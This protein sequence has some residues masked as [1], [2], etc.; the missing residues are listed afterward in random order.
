MY[1]TDLG[2]KEKAAQLEAESLEQEPMEEL[3]LEGIVSGLIDS[4][5]DYIDMEI[6]PERTAAEDYYNGKEFG[7]EEAGRSRVVSM[8]V[9]D[10]ISLMMPQIMR[11]FFGPEKVVEYIPRMVED[12]PGAEQAT[13]FVNSVVLGQDNDFFLTFHAI[14]KDALLKRAGVA[15]VWYETKEE[16]E[17]QEFTG[18]DEQGLQALLA[19]PDIEATSV[20]SY[21]D[22]D[23]QPQ[24]PQIGPDGMPMPQE[25]PQLYDLC[26][27]RRFDKGKIRVEAIPLEEFLIDRRAR[28]LDDSAVVAH[29]RYLTVSELVAMGYDYDEVL[30]H[31][32]DEDE[33]QTNLEWISRH[34]NASY[35]GPEGAGES[36]RKAL[37]VEAFAR[38][39][40]DQDGRSELRRFCCIG[41]KYQ[42]LHHSPVN[43]IPF[44]LF[45]GYPMPHRWQGQS[46]YDLCKDIQ[47][48]KSAVMR[49]TLDSL[50][51]AIFPRTVVV[52][53]ALVGDDVL[54]NRVGSIIRVRQQGAVQSLATPFTGKESFPLLQ[55]LDQVKEDRTGM[56]KSSMGLDPSV[57]QS[58]T[59]A[60]VSHTQAASQAQIELVCR[61]LAEI[62]L[63][64]LFKRILKLLVSHQDKS[65]MVRLR[66]GWTPIDPRSWDASM[67]VAVNV[68]LGMGTTEERAQHMMTIA[69]KQE[70]IL[71]TLGPENPLVDI[72]RYHNTLKKLVEFAGFKDAG[73]FWSDPA[74]FQ[75]PPPKEPE[76]PT[77][78]QIY[79]EAQVDKIRADML[80][81]KMRVELEREKMIRDDDRKRDELE[82]KLAEA[83]AKHQTQLDTQALRAQM[84][85]DRELI[86]QQ[87][88]LEQQILNQQNQVGS[89]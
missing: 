42:I 56:S 17:Q 3:E 72:P 81:D 45:Q 66:N 89:A 7:D 70:Q 2:T 62:G 22:P 39:D 34:P 85:R 88:A 79:A 82:V 47:R 67:D 55:Y 60:A 46:I 61:N 32:G 4:A 86:R 5:V 63:K 69:A 26:I 65:R 14:I 30:E 59:K 40:Y 49:N 74:E 58:T 51:Q 33:F 31:A 19:D 6:G 15:K 18:I 50:A 20:T 12:V 37:F 48:I 64:P 1:E 43:E 75:P 25:E 16:L 8:D 27:R 78:D 57:L 10:T 77:P 84:E 21:P 71:Q 9:R 11:L 35:A 23:A 38:V 68:A 24:E 13:D 73:Q 80:S 41:P 36:N 44:I 52:E 29:R 54:S 76:P 83:S 53:N 87:G 28:S